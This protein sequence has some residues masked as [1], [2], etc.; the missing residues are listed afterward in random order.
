MNTKN[1]YLKLFSAI[2]NIII[3]SIITLYVLSLT[4]IFINF[5]NENLQSAK[6][7]INI[8]EQ[9]LNYYSNSL[10]YYSR[11]ISGNPTFQNSMN[12][13][14]KNEL[15]GKE[16]INMGIE[17]GRITL[18]IPYIYGAAIYDKNKSIVIS[19]EIPPQALDFKTDNNGVWV[20]SQKKDFNE[21]IHNSLS[22]IRPFFKY[23]SGELIGYVE[24][25]ISD[26]S[27][28]GVYDI[29]GLESDAFFLI[30]NSNGDVFS[31]S[32]TNINETSINK[33]IK[34]HIN[35]SI[36]LDKDF[37]IYSEKISNL[38]LDAIY[39]LPT[40]SFLSDAFSLAIIFLLMFIILLFLSS[41]ISR[42]LSTNITKPLY[43][44][45]N[46]IVSINK[47]KDAKIL[48]Y[49][50]DI[51]DINILI[52]TFNDMVISQNK[53]KQDI[54]E[55]HLRLLNEQIKPHF[56]YN[57]LENISALANLD[58]KDRLINIIN[59]LSAF[60]RLVLDKG[61]AFVSI[62]DEL[63]TITAYMNIMNI[64]Y[65]DKFSYEISCPSSLYNYSCPKLI[66][67]P[68][69]ENSI[70]HGMKGITYKG[71][72]KII[73]K[74]SEDNIEFNII[75]NGIGI[76][77][78]ESEFKENGF[79]LKHIRS[80]LKHYYGSQYDIYL[81]NNEEKGCIVVFKI[82]KENRFETQYN[83]SR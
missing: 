70:Y 29:L 11:I 12:L 35:N 51:Q 30:L 25:S 81:N 69:I 26:K 80:L 10:K 76:N 57:T 74:D 46:H 15:N 3:I 5:K 34:K 44:I 48:D 60:Y 77:N 21:I 54:I 14:Y 63:K 47:S 45:I 72:L 43:K 41:I 50:T 22:Y 82:R 1:F 36:I 65:M 20:Y 55:I 40:N 6:H 62:Y 64:R 24:L 49:S 4:L 18:P 39:I 42:N 79:A 28:S 13:Y 83:N 32:S 73:I 9:Q 19:S 67:Q 17:I 78:I 68:L 37:F 66:L 58:E 8:L 16:K 23:S 71:L 61:N 53:L 52:N 7:K 56:L 27:I 59:N 2:R 38:R 33:I 31:V 75:D